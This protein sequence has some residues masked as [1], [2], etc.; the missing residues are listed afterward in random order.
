MTLALDHY[1][2]FGYDE[3]SK[4]NNVKQSHTDA[5]SDSI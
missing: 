5:K 2:E 1:K 3:A 4:I